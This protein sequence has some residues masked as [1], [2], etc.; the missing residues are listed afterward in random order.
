MKESRSVS[1]GCSRSQTEYHSLD[2]PDN[3]NV[4]EMQ[5]SVLCRPTDNS[6]MV[7]GDLY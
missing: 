7:T 5:L 2:S 4:S 1:E 3:L 6:A